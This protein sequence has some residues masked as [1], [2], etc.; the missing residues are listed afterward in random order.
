MCYILPVNISFI[1]IYLS[2]KNFIT[3]FQNLHHVL[4]IYIFVSNFSHE[5][6]NLYKCF[7]TKIYLLLILSNRN[8]IIEF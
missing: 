6:A 4:I 2:I 1:I 8:N 5:Y 7:V 3:K